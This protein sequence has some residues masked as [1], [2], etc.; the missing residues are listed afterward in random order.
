MKLPEPSD[1]VPTKVPTAALVMMVTVL[2]GMSLV[3][4]YSNVQRLRRDKIETV[5]VTPVATPTA[6]P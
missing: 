1:P 3:S 5:V 4:I 2:A 6:T